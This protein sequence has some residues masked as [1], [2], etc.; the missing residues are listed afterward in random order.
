MSRTVLPVPHVRCRLVKGNP[1]LNGSR[2]LRISLLAV[3]SAALLGSG[4]TAATAAPAD[5]PAQD[6]PQA[7]S[8]APV[9]RLIVGYEKKAA[10]AKSDAEAKEEPRPRAGRPAS[11][12][13]SN[14]GSAPAPRSWTSATG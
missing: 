1:T 14:D 3:T 6:R 10:E 4:V 12:C 11:P 13:P 5:R 9:E 7:A 2:R 8:E